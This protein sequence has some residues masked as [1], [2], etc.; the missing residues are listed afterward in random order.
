VA[1]G[2]GSGSRHLSWPS[3]EAAKEGLSRGR[4]HAPTSF[5]TP[6]LALWV[7]I[8][9]CLLGHSPFAACLQA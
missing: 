4:I 9:V 3:V 2:S 5:V 7:P 1:Q 8:W 6:S